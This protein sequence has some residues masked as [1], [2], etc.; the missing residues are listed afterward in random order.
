M[1]VAIHQPDFMPWYG[2]FNK[3][4]SADVWVVL[5]HTENNPRDAAFWGRRVKILVNG[6]EH[7]LSLTLNKPKEKEKIGIPI[8]EMTL[9]LQN[10]KVMSKL[11][12]TMHM[13]YSKAPNFDEFIHLVDDYFDSE[14]KR[15]MPRNMKFIDNIMSILNIDTQ[16]VY[17]S[18]LVIESSSTDMLVE[19][20]DR[21][22]GDVYLSGTGAEGYQDVDL[23]KKNGIELA[24]NEFEH[25]KYEQLGTD[26]FI[27]GLSIIDMLFMKGPKFVQKHLEM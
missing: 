10:K 18:D 12:K 22:D 27:P 24:F 17:S 23:Y 13:A 3:I 16:I 21:L 11:K 7:W 15:L 9:N 25:P 1:I 2:F 5:D 19:I 8:R 14:E 6:Q 4:N 26:Q 20:I